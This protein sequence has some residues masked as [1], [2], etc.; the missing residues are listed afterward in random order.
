MKVVNLRYNLYGYFKGSSSGNS[1]ISSEI[2]KSI[3]VR[4]ENVHVQIRG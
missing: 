3:L 1:E 4:T 2:L